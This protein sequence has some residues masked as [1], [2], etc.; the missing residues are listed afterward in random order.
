[1]P[2]VGKVAVTIPRELL[3]ALDRER[4]RLGAS[5]SAL[6]TAAVRQWLTRQGRADDDARYVEGYLRVPE[7][8]FGDIAAAALRSWEPWE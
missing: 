5:R 8:P 1:M 3:E 6:V 2:N 7:Q 4:E